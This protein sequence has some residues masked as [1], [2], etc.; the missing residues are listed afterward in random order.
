MKRAAEILSVF[1]MKLFS[2]TIFSIAA[3]GSGYV[4]HENVFLNDNF[5]QPIP[6]LSTSKSTSVSSSGVVFKHLYLSGT[7][8]SLDRIDP[9]ATN[10][11]ITQTATFPGFVTN[12][13]FIL[14]QFLNSNFAGNNG[15]QSYLNNWQEEGEF[16]G[17]FSGV[18]QTVNSGNCPAGNCLRFG[19]FNVNLNGAAVRRMADLSG[20]ISA[21][22]NIESFRT[23]V[24]GTNAAVDLEIS[25]D[26]GATWVTLKTYSLN[27]FDSNV[28]LDAFDIIDYISPNTQIRFI[29]SGTTSLLSSWIYFDNI[30]IGIKTPEGTNMVSFSQLPALCDDLN[31]VETDFITVNTYVNDLAN[32]LSANPNVIAKLSYGDN[33]IITLTSPIYDNSSN[34]ITWSDI[35]PTSSLIPAGAAIELEISTSDHT[36]NFEVLYDSKE[37]P[38]K[39]EL[40]VSTFIDVVAYEIYD[41]PYPNGNIITSTSAG[42]TIYM[43]AQVEDPFG[44]ADITALHFDDSNNLY[45]GEAVDSFGCT[46]I[47]EYALTAPNIDG[48]YT[49]KTI[50][51]EGF[52]GTV[53]SNLPNAIDI[54]IYNITVPVFDQ[55]SS[56][57]RCKGEEVLNFNATS[58]F[59]TDIRYH[60]DAESLAGGVEIDS[61]FGKVVFN[62][63]YDGTTVITATAYGCGGSLSSNF[64]I[65]TFK[66]VEIPVFEL[67][68]SSERCVGA[69]VELIS[70]STLYSTSTLYSLD[71]LSIL[72]GVEIVEENGKVSFPSS[73]TGN[74]IVY[75]TAQGCNGPTT[76]AHVIT[77]NASVVAPTFV[78]GSD[79]ENC[80]TAPLVYE[81]TSPNDDT[82]IFTIDATSEAA[83]VTIDSLTG[84][85][86]FEISYPGP[87][88]IKAIAEGCNGTA[89]GVHVVKLSNDC[90]PIAEDDQILVDVG[91]SAFEDVLA[92]D[93]DINND[94]DPT[95]LTIVQQPINGTVTI[96]NGEVI[97]SPIGNFVGN[98][99]F[100]Y[101]ICDEQ[102]NCDKAT[103][104]I[105]IVENI[106]DP[107]VQANQLQEFYLPFPEE[108][109]YAS[110]RD[111]SCDAGAQHSANVRSVIAIKTPYPT[112]FIKYDHWEDGYEPDLSRPIQA[113]TE[114]WGDGNLT[115]GIAPGYPND[116]LIAGSSIILD[117]TF[118]YTPPRDPS[119]IVHDGKDKIVSSS[120]ITISKISGDEPLFLFQAAKTSIY[121]TDRFG[122]SFTIPFG[123]DLGNEFQYTALFIRAMKD[124]TIVNVD[125]AGDGIIDAN[126]QT[127]ILN[128]GEVLFVEG[129]PNNVNQLNDLKSGA[130]V[131]ASEKVGLDV[132]F[133][134]LD[135]YGT[136]NINLQPAAFYSSTYYTPV[137][138]VNADAPAKIYMYNKYDYDLTIN[139]TSKN[140]S[141]SFDIAAESPTPVLLPNYETAYKF[142]NLG[143]ES[144]VAI[145]VIDSDNN[146]ASYDWAFSLTGA[147]QLSDFTSI[148]WAP[149][150]SDGSR[151]DG[152]IWVT[153]AANTTLYVKLDGD[154]TSG[155]PNVAPCGRSYDIAQSINEFEAYRL[156]DNTDNDQSGMALFTCDGTSFFSVF[157]EDPSTAVLGSPSMDVGTTMEPLCSER[158]ILA[159]EDDYSTPV[160]T[161]IDIPVLDND[162]SF[163]ATIDPNKLYTN[164]L[165][166]PL[167]GTTSIDASTHRIIYTPNPGWEGI[168]YFEYEICSVEDDYLCDV[169]LVS[170]YVGNCNSNAITVVAS[171]FTY[172]ESI[173]DNGTYDGEPT[174]EN[175]DV[176]L[177]WDENSNGEIDTP[178]DTLILS[179]TSNI[180]GYYEF[181]FR[182]LGDFIIQ[183]DENNGGFSPGTLNTVSV[184]FSS[185]NSCENDFYLGL[186]PIV[187]PIDDLLTTVVNS[188]FSGNVVNND[189]GDINISSISIG[190]IHPSN[191]TVMMNSNGIMDYSPNL[192]FIGLDSFNYQICSNLDPNLCDSAMVY[193][194]VLCPVVDG[195]NQITGT[196]FYDNNQDG[197]RDLSDDGYPFVSIMLYMDENQDGLLDASDTFVSATSTDENGNYQ[198]L[199]TPV[200]FIL[201]VD[202]ASVPGISMTT[203]NIEIVHFSTSGQSDCVN[204]FGLFD[205][206]ASCP[207]E[208]IDDYA[209]TEVSQSITIDILAN[210]FDANGDL[211]AT[212]VAIPNNSP[213]PN[214]TL[215]INSID[216]SITYLPNSTFAGQDIFYYEVCDLS[217]PT[218]LC[219]TAVVY[220]NVSCAIIPNQNLISGYVFEDL[221]GDGAFN[222]GEN[223][224]ENIKVYLHED[225]NQN[226]LLDADEAP[227]D[228]INSS[229]NGA[230]QFELTQS[231]PPTVM[232]Q[233]ISVAEDDA[234]ERLSDGATFLLSNDLDFGDDGDPDLVGLRFN[235]IDIPNN[236]TILDVYLEFEARGNTSGAIDLYIYCEA[237]DNSAI[238]STNNYDLSNRARTNTGVPWSNVE[239]WIGD[240]FY[241]TPQLSTIV[242]EVISRPG[243]NQ[244]NAITFLIEGRP[245]PRRAESFGGEGGAGPKLVI[246]YEVDSGF[247]NHFITS[248]EEGTLPTGTEMTTSNIAVTTF[249]DFVQ[250]DCGNNFGYQS[251]PGGCSPIA[252][253]DYASTELAT[254]VTIDVLANDTDAD[255]DINPASVFIPSNGPIPNGNVTIMPGS[256][257][258]EYEP[259][260]IFTGL[261]SFYYV[262]CDYSTPIIKC[263]TATVFVNVECAD[264]P[265][266]K[267]ISG[268]VF[269]DF[270]GDGNHF[271]NENGTG[272]IKVYLHEDLNQNGIWDAGDTTIDSI[273]SDA[274]GFYQFSMPLTS[275]TQ[276]FFRDI[277]GGKDDAE[278]SLVTGGVLVGGTSMGLGHDGDLQMVGLRFNN[279][280]IPSNSNILDVYLEFYARGFSWLATD[281]TVHGEDID[282]SIEYASSN[283]NIT[284]RNKTDASVPW[285]NVP[286]WYDNNFYQT[287]NLS[288][289][290]QEIIS[291]PGWTA[292]NNMSMLIDGG[293]ERRRA[294]T[295]ESTGGPP[296]R[297]V[298]IYKESTYGNHFITSID[299][300]GLPEGTEMTTDNNEVATF[301][302]TNTS[303]CGNNFG[304]N[305]SHLN[306]LAIGDINA[307]EYNNPVAGNVLTNDQAVRGF[308][309]DTQ[310]FDVYGGSV[311]IHQNGNYTFTPQLDYVGEAGFSYQICDSVHPSLC[312][313]T[314]VIIDIIDCFSVNQNQVIGMEDCFLHENIFKLSANLLSN[315]QDVNGSNLQIN[316]TPITY[317]S[318]GVLTI[319]SD[320]TFI[321]QPNTNAQ[322]EDEFSYQVC[323]D[324]NPQACDTVTVNI[325]LIDFTSEPNIYA[326][327]DANI[328]AIGDTLSGNI[329]ANDN[330]TNANTFLVDIVPIVAPQHGSL[331]LDATGDYQYIPDQNY[332]GNDQ[333][334]YKVCDNISNTTCDTATVYLT[335]LDDRIHLDFRVMLQGALHGNTDTLMRADLV[336]QNLVPLVQPYSVDFNPLFS[337]RLTHGNGG[338]E[339]T[340]NAILSAN[341]STKDAI[342]DWVLIELRD[343]VDSV[344]VIKSISA[345]VQRDGDIVDARS[346]G[347]LYEKDL[348]GQFFVCIKHRNHLGAMTAS[349]IVINGKKATVDF[350][351]L[352]SSELFHFDGYDGLE[353]TSANGLNALWA[354]NANA[355]TKVKYD[356]MLNDQIILVGEI[357]TSPGNPDSNLN[358][359][360]TIGY[361]QGDINMD[362]KTKYDGVLNDRIIIQFINLTYPNNI[363]LL[364]NYNLLI[365]Q[366][367]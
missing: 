7:N 74:T 247:G 159:N 108:Q 242:H 352:T 255:F 240:N 365:E 3:I 252:A 98:D 58:S 61:I 260:P 10:N 171:G 273:I 158:L 31:I 217:T 271:A 11:T 26:G 112:I 25:K 145:E 80:F 287:P 49:T 364:N 36:L 91:E 254:A 224:G 83:G 72:G 46:K 73:W 193:L 42:T 248:I 301:S 142:E 38:S 33:D 204:N 363:G 211:D 192:D 165:L 282:S 333:F 172:Y 13:H 178:Q 5:N 40:P 137:P 188:N 71:S 64:I 357:I 67:G 170:V 348:I 79:S 239:P 14:D 41:A 275:P 297:L 276:S 173:P 63:T 20:A 258:I 340:T 22:L 21:D 131:T 320:G 59:S 93:F 257:V 321:Y 299:T 127:A 295:Y 341:T 45:P 132:L 6:S 335:I 153:P 102:G 339:V 57:D 259:Y 107:C 68:T 18:V 175:I 251:C 37:F 114:I 202:R 122:T 51:S 332:V 350:T 43:R 229:I 294:E 298:I 353:Q 123:E 316:T 200:D 75:A 223:G 285:N 163:L 65:N 272:N 117:N 81:V 199:T 241:Q 97:F 150:S 86:V 303:D 164:G 121:D 209:T 4:V 128:E 354:G 148:A 244:E 253:D 334:L 56:L 233:H 314:T 84:Y 300:N 325:F 236:A 345:L 135:C 9:V 141:G 309:I 214:G 85:L 152:P 206:V 34:L 143:G 19:G 227:I 23:G 176:S 329:V 322:K 160:A 256:G 126:D 218:I 89:I 144:F 39:I 366:V 30:Q 269:N 32:S 344:T 267:I 118:D 290:V 109:L 29:G 111:A 313:S 162:D 283:F 270:N 278:E 151:N 167:N 315:D 356:G 221:N 216:G 149:G 327:D 119:I 124:G 308:D 182:L 296:A 2:L 328:G 304:Y 207:P 181:N 48:Q 337:N 198:F 351:T 319:N 238:F 288:P 140:N 66:D 262:V 197:I 358:Y 113:S 1:K 133:G 35:L 106:H 222:F 90:A 53:E 134:G 92:N 264:T 168:E 232:V 129:D 191:G 231:I 359:N 120:D 331:T 187:N 225:I 215:S 8:Q 346:G 69:N 324:L 180:S 347:N 101:Q 237:T 212:S 305:Y 24:G 95:T 110:F 263:D 249:S 96:A 342:V 235:N 226:G 279:I 105:N 277:S 87:I 99:E 156:L 194:N 367:K 317:P 228:S 306:P 213:I 312:D 16:D 292:G 104:Y 307:T 44:Y 293:P 28:V 189:L 179:T 12:D 27:S 311:V 355:D 184:S 54:C 161:P 78:L 234:E 243:W 195:V 186:S 47:Y 291:R 280:D 174:V 60:L 201:T 343:P 268:Y 190:E 70:A 139:W 185:L 246:E 310:P 138:T 55:G 154:V 245:S 94:I 147:E 281:L 146:G 265:N 157:G 183:V 219:D 196:V 52:E 286:V 115:N 302:A 330:L 360:N 361:Y 130:L 125:V 362:G 169:A 177:Y 338:H 326:T 82:I 208:A 15:S 261:D 100:V 210:D 62:P 88:T 76:A 203:D 50:A 274:N 284:N 166:Q 230:Y 336:N 205:C 103:V 318:K 250:S 155:S 323:N 77:T 116:I 289:I 17:P 349:P 136:R 266:E 220:I